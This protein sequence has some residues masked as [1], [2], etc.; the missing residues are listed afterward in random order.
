MKATGLGLGKPLSIEIRHVYTGQ[1][2]QLSFF[3]ERQDDRIE[4]L[5]AELRP[6]GQLLRNR[7]WAEFVQRVPFVNSGQFGP[8]PAVGCDLVDERSFLSPLRLNQPR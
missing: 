5:D 7:R 1:Y 6:G 4:R 2:P 3:D 8:G